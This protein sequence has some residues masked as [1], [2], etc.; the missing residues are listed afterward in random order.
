MAY[1]L[2]HGRLEGKK[3]RLV[4]RADGLIRQGPAFSP[5]VFSSDA[6]QTREFISV[7]LDEGGSMS[8]W[9]LIDHA[10]SAIT[11]LDNELALIEQVKSEARAQS[12]EATICTRKPS[13]V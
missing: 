9:K 8:V 6:F 12:S 3:A 10:M 5:G 13:S 2:K 4:R 7:E 11:D 1:S